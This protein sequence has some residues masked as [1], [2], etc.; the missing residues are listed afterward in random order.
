MSRPCQPGPLR[1]APLLFAGFVFPILISAP[2]AERPSGASSQGLSS[3][4]ALEPAAAQQGPPSPGAGEKVDPG[5]VLSGLEAEELARLFASA[6]LHLDPQAG[7]LSIPATIDVRSELLEYLLVAPHGAAH[8]S[9]FETA[10]DIRLLNTAL[11]TLG[12]TP[13]KNAVWFAKDP[14]PSE[15]ELRDGASP[16]EIALPEGDAFYLYAGWREGDEVYF[17]RVEDL[18]RNLGGERGMQRHAWVYLGSRMAVRGARATEQFA[19]AAEG[20]LINIAFFS[21]GNT[22]LT[23][24]LD[25]CVDQTVWMA[26]P[27]LLPPS[28]SEVRFVFSRHRL[29]APPASLLERLPRLVPEA[30]EADRLGGGEGR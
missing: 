24:A 19:A 20:N 16:Y 2:R 15:Q 1:R 27:W 10:V 8:E 6:G 7:L 23:A 30:S 12:V 3:S 11:L 17:Y 21:A 4:S 5:P 13:G 29:L 18:L 28:H 14:Q 22:L 9:L 25:E 26:N